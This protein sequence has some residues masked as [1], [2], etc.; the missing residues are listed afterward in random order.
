MNGRKIRRQA[1]LQ[2]L[3][4]PATETRFA[5]ALSTEKDLLR[6]VEEVCAAA[7]SA[8]GA[9]P[10]LAMVFVSP[11]SVPSSGG[12]RYESLA[13]DLCS[14]LGTRNLLGATGESIVG[15]RREIEGQ[16]ALSLWLASLPGA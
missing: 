5:A 6:A 2:E 3:S 4:L 13:A 7:G 15:G 1:L 16:P 12:P 9:V 11:H 8:L 14:R 10:D